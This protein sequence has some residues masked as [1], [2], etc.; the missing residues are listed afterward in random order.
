MTHLIEIRDLLIRREKRAVLEIEQLDIERGEI[1]A[2]IG[3]NGAGKSTLLLVLARLLKAE[4]GEVRFNGQAI[5]SRGD[6]A[7]RRRIG[8]VMQDAL[9]L[10]RSVFDNVATGLRFRHLPKDEVTH[11]VDEWLERLGI[12]H[13]RQRPAMQ[14]SG[15][16]SRRVALARA[17]VLQPDLLLLDEPFAALDRT[18]R[19][20]LQEDLKS[21]LAGAD[22][23]VVFSTHSETDVQKL[24]E[25][26]IELDGGKLIA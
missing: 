10:N 20:K 12:P 5:T 15:G 21:I 8:L 7:Y 25:R 14:I 16:E 11:R 6:L 2:I 9:L 26:K 4:R 1:L 13:L 17:F 18:S 3:Q 19:H 24:A 22:M 23:T